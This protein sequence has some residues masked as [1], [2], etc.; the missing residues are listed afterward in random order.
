MGDVDS[1]DDL[2]HG[3]EEARW[4]WTEAARIQ[5]LHFALA[6]LYRQGGKDKRTIRTLWERIAEGESG[7]RA[8]GIDPA[9][10]IRGHY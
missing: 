9:E 10:A 8:A 4:A 6:A 1:H 3:L 5:N 7:L 2:V